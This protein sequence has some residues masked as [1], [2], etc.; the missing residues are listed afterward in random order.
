MKFYCISGV[1]RTLLSPTWILPLVPVYSRYFEWQGEELVVSDQHSFNVL[2][3]LT[4]N[5][6]RIF[7]SLKFE[8]PSN[9]GWIRSSVD[10]DGNKTLRQRTQS[11]SKSLHQNHSE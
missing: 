1:R 10:K 5:Y 2:T 11:S 7:M 8:L 6:P 4:L 9:M 3:M